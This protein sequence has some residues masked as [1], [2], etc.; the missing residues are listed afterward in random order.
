MRYA[1]A[2]LLFFAAAPLSAAAPVELSPLAYNHPGLTVDLGVGLWSFPIPLDWDDDGDYDLVVSCPDKPSNGI[3][4][5]ENPANPRGG[6]PSPLMPV[7][8]P[9]VRLRAAPS[10]YVTPSYVDG[11]T[12]VLI[13]GREL[14]DFRAEAFGKSVAVYEKENIHP[15]AVRANQWKLADYDGDGRL[16]LLVGVGDWKEYGWDNAFDE[17]GQWTNGPL[18][19]YV[20]LLRNETDND[21]PR[22]AAPQKLTAAGEPIDVYGRPSPNLEDFD[23]DGDLDLL[24]GEFVD[25][26]TYFQNV[27]T[28]AKP[29]YAAGRKLTHEGQPLTVDLEMPSVVAF[30]WDRDG[31]AD[32]IVGDEDGRVAFFQHTG[33]TVDGLPQFLPP[34]YFQQQAD[35]IKCGALSTPCGV[36]CDSD[37]DID[38]LCGNTAGYLVFFENL[39]PG[40]EGETPKWA[41]GQ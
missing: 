35:K 34:R 40:G 37:G 15:G 14:V 5:F 21:Q 9:G 23:G 4:L 18:H 27:G 3:Y 8:L 29:E 17:R 30:D 24:C 25:T 13:P 22:Y 2:C 10:H 11:Q 6:K 41:A 31:D 33:E 1:F 20:Y 12:R 19:G 16:D 7:F 38:I 32:L 26:L 28:R 36:D 39:G